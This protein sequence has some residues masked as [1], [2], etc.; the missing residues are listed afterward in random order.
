MNKIGKHLPSLSFDKLEWEHYKL[1]HDIQEASQQQAK[2]ITQMKAKVASRLKPCSNKR[3]QR[4]PW[5]SS[6]MQ[7]LDCSRISDSLSPHLPM[8][9]L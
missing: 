7:A 5:Q 9:L 6:A 3:L 1:Y 4:P 2:A 8:P